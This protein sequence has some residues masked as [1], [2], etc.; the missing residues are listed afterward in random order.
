MVPDQTPLPPLI[1][2]GGPTA[3]GKTALAITLAE[4]IDGEVISADSRQVYRG[5]DIGTAKVSSADR[6]RIPHHGLDL[7][8]PDEPF[9]VADFRRHALEVL[10]QIAARGRVAILAGGTGLYLRAVARGLPV[11]DLGHDPAVRSEIERRLVHEGLPALV[12]DLRRLAPSVA[13]TIDLANPRRV[14]RALERALL[15]GDT[16]PP[17]PRGYP[18]PVVWLGL[19]VDPARHADAIEARAREQFANGLLDEAAALLERY[20]EDLRAFGAMGYREAFDVLAGRATLE[21]AIATDTGRT[22]AYARRQRTW[23]RSEPDIHW[24]PPGAERLG[25]ALTLVRDARSD[26]WLLAGEARG[27][28]REQLDTPGDRTP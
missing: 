7:V 28:L 4:R 26:A 5:M 8:A 10:P 3:S 9:T 24:L 17:P 21:Q 18:A 11:D 16:P 19:A 1:V 12:A 14:T 15:V 22:R 2:I 20:P 6:A 13:A 27:A 25:A 23:F